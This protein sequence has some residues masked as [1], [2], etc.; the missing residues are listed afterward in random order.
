MK[1]D[2]EL[3]RE[4][5]LFFEE[6]TGPEH[7]GPGEIEIGGYDPLAIHHHVLLL[8]E[9]GLLTCERITSSTT[10]ERLVDALPFDLSWEGHEFLDAARDETIWS[11][12]KE[13]LKDKG[14]TVGLAVLQAL[15]VS[16]AKQR[17][18]LA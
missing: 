16:L 12:A 13:L 17:L 10:P 9:A 7:V 3:I 18:S 1:R 6:K 4:L 14:M 15:L 11:K 2:M 5:L 8:C